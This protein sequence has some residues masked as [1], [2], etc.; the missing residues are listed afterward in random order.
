[1]LWRIADETNAQIIHNHGLWLPANHSAARVARRRYVPLITTAH[2]MLTSWSLG[3]K[4]WKKKL[5]LR[6][7]QRRDLEAAGVLHATSRMEADSLRAFGL[8]QPLAVL[9]FGIDPPPLAAP[10]KEPPVR[11]VLFLSRIHPVKGL[12]NLVKA[13]AV[14][15]PAGWRVRIVGPDEVGHRADVERE[16]RSLGLQ[17]EF[18]FGGQADAVSKWAIYRGADVFIL[19]SFT[20]NFGVVVPEALACELPVIATKGAPWAELAEH[21]CGWWIDSGLEP[22]VG[23]LREATA[24]TD[25]VRREMGRRGRQLVLERYAWPAIARQFREVYQWLALKAPPPACVLDRPTEP[26]VLCPHSIKP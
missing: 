16:I 26:C 5:A 9:P 3:H 4:S 14:L 12:L 10:L 1:M 20:E 22:L 21:R 13:W 25:S 8:R 24:A 15:R 7:Y 2:G 6:L 19:P 11:E 17:Q 18:I 23:A